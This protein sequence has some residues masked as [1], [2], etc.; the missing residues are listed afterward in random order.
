MEIEDDGRA[1]D[2]TQSPAPQRAASLDTAQVGGWGIPIIRRFSD[3]LC[4]CRE[5][6]RN[7]LKLAFR[8]AHASQF[9]DVAQQATE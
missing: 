7:V 6:G 1:F 3:G 9:D 4:Y 5:R 2:P 8:L